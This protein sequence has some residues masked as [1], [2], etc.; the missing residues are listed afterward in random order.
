MINMLTYSVFPLFDDR[1]IFTINNDKDW[2]IIRERTRKMGIK[3]FTVIDFANNKESILYP[4]KNA[5]YEV[6]DR[7]SYHGNYR[8]TIVENI[9]FNN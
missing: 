1:I 3:D 4:F 8:R 2:E 7:F 5:E 6:K 9:R